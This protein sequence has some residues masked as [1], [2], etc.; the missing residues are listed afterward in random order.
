MS[1]RVEEMEV[2][3][4]QKFANDYISNYTQVE[5]FFHYSPYDPLTYS[6]RL[7]ELQRRSFARNEV[8]EIIRATMVKW[9]ISPKAEE[10]LNQLKQSDSVVVVG[11]QQA[12]LLLGPLYTIHKM[13]TILQLSQQKRAELGIPVIPI[14][15]IAGEDHDFD[16]INH[17]LLKRVEG[18]GVEKYAFTPP[19][20]NN[21]QSISLLSFPKQ[22]VLNWTREAFTKLSETEFTKGLWDVTEQAILSSESYSDFFTQLAN[23]LFA[24]YGLLFIDSAD[25]Q[26]RKLESN[27]FCT[28]LQQYDMIH[29]KVMNTTENLSDKGYDPQVQLGQ[30]ASLLFLIQD[31]ERK[32]LEKI[33]NNQ[34]RT[35]DGQYTYSLEE[36]LHLAETSPER[37][38]NNVLTR[39]FMQETVLPTLAFVGGPGEITYWGQLSGYF[40]ELGMKLPPIVPRISMTL[41]EQPISKLLSKYQIT[42]LDIMSGMDQIRG[43]WLEK[44]TK[45]NF[46]QLFTVAKEDIATAHSELF[47]KLKDIPGIEQLQS[48]NLERILNEV[49]FI[50]KQSLVSLEQQHAA[51]LRQFDKLEYALYPEQK[52][53]E[54]IHNSIYVLNKHGQALIK[55]LMQQKFEINGKHKLVLI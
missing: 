36:L 38:S 51:S 24:D 40:E 15:W 17:I 6:T 47:E 44:Q 3:Q 32:L 42:L 4:Q 39:P 54:R 29:E 9:G 7:E 23:T 55:E 18:K 31:G 13:I 5:S 41:I 11:G 33:N 26:L 27:V 21:K 10:H 8:S 52:L 1:C 30:N 22:E 12:G 49:S 20:G 37:F 16:E 46:E 43:Q 34:F 25:P 53:Q 35:K 45:L 48:T 19:E 50:E 2:Q 28:I 14:F